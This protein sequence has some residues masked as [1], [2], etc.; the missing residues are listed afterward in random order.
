M[1]AEMRRAADIRADS[2]DGI[3][4]IIER[5]LNGEIVSPDDEYSLIV[6][7]YVIAKL[8]AK[9]APHSGYWA[10]ALILRARMESL[11][12]R[13]QPDRV[14]LLRRKNVGTRIGRLIHA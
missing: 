1:L 3:A 8:R 9:A 4:A 12:S 13:M 10:T 14:K 11:E 2:P 5:L 6:H 7:H